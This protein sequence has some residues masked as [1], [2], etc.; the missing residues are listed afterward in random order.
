MYVQAI[1]SVIAGIQVEIDQVEQLL[2]KKNREMRDILGENGLADPGETT[3]HLTEETEA[4]VFETNLCNLRA[5]QQFLSLLLSTKQAA[6]HQAVGIGT[7]VGLRYPDGQSRRFL[8]VPCGVNKEFTTPLGPILL[9]SDEASL[10][11]ALMSKKGC[12]VGAKVRVNDHLSVT[13]EQ[14]M[15]NNPSTQD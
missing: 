2:R 13:I 6:T 3:L 7:I 4:S 12:Q 1:E 5:T 10:A 9:I 11:Q 8:V 15:W 14:I